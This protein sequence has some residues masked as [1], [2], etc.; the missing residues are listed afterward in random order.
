[1]RGASQST[2]EIGSLK[3]DEGKAMIR[4]QV[5]LHPAESKKLIGKA[6]FEM[7]SVQKAL[8][9]GI[10]VIHP[11]STAYFLM[12]YITGKKPKGIWLVGM[13]AT[14]GTCVEGLTQRAFEADKYQELSDPANFPFSWVFRKGKFEKGLK[15]A[16]ILGEMGEGDVYIKGVNAIDSHGYVGVLLA[17]LAG[18]TIGKAL[19]F[20]RE[21]KFK[22]IYLAG[23]EKFIPTSIQ[24]VAKETGRAN[25]S[26]ALGI[27]CGLLPIKAKP[28]TEIEAL[29]K[30]AGVEAV[31]IAAGGVGGGEGSTIMVIKGEEGEV[32]KAMK[33][34][35]EIKG[36]KL[37]I[38]EMPDCETC[39]LPGCYFSGNKWIKTRD[40]SEEG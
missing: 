34:V 9:E 35:K 6:V 22:I 17:S 20:Q 5:V 32:K 10:I 18:G 23:L 13:I 30:L 14:R 26:D 12:E 36:A 21:K 24:D 15:L 29:K 40:R 37:P 2:F 39:H 19:S 16:Q 7:D 38:V 8:R 3:R 1:M 11:S 31:P 27:P 4:A 33:L 28:V 25:T